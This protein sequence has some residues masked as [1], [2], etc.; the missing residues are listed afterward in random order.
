MDTVGPRDKILILDFGSQT[1]QLIGRR[2]RDLGVYTEIV[3]G[4]AVLTDEVLFG[5]S[6]TEHSSCAGGGADSNPANGNNIVKGNNT[7]NGSNTA[8]GNNAVNATKL[9]GIILS[10]SPE[11]VYTPE[12]AAPDKRVYELGLPLLGICYGLQRMTVDHGG[13]VEPLP[14]REYGGVEVKVIQPAA[15]P[16]TNLT[17]RFL[18]GF[19]PAVSLDTI[20]E[21][22]AAPSKAEFSFTA[23]MSHG[24]TL[25]RP[26]PGFRQ[27]GTSVTGYPAVLTHESKPWFGLQFHPEVTHTERGSEILAAFVFGVCGC[28][29]SWSMEQYVEELRAALPKRVGTNPVLLLISGGV[30]STVAGALLLKTLDADK[31]HL[32]YMDTGMM[33]KGE[34]ETVS[35]NLNRLGAK[36]LHIIHCETEFLSALKGLTEPEAK[37]KAIGDLF[38]TIQEREV[39]RLGLPDTYF[40]AQGTLYT[41][42]IESGKGVG[43]KAHLIKSHH[44]VGSPLV[45][46]KR[47]AGRIIEPLDRLYKDEVRRLG[48]ILG[49]DDEVVRRHPFPGPGLAV[50]ILGEV[51]QEKCDILREADA[52]F[53]EELKKRKTFKGVS[54]YDEIWQAFAVLL[55]IRSVGVAGDAR[56]YGWVLALRAIVSADGMT[57]DVYPFPMKDLLEISTLITNTVKDIGRV[58]YDISSK[59]PATIEWE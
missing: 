26:A 46:A 7:A 9:R 32:M 2:I 30:D 38:I 1:T 14:K 15:V 37:R 44:N 57:A 35:A 10:G 28:T 49:I 8:N 34:T 50:R 24:D 22:N 54:L 29:K 43:K 19:D 58:T 39:A 23:W 33:R 59:P 18:A 52:I 51:T 5:S 12:G 41:D 31:V 47:K 42:L 20:T 17:Q 27:Y 56:K 21:G 25:T 4:D 55:P 13:V 53:I 45:D 48:R 3:P 11:S 40:L 16:N 36:H 6:G